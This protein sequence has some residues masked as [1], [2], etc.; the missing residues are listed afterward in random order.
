MKVTHLSG[1]Q[2]AR[3]PLRFMDVGGG[4]G[5][6]EASL[7]QSVFTLDPVSEGPMPAQRYKGNVPYNSFGF[8]RS[9][10]GFV[11][12]SLRLTL[13]Q[14]PFLPSILQTELSI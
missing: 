3:Q 10:Q 11:L 8:G 4:D 13:S 12:G 2:G 1:D 6:R 9:T 14:T 5:G 7:H